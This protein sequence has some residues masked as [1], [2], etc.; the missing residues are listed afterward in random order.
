[1]LALERSFSRLPDV[2]VMQSLL[3]YYTD[4]VNYF[5][6]KEEPI[7]EY[8]Q[9]KIKDLVAKMKPAFG[10]PKAKDADEKRDLLTRNVM[11]EMQE[12]NIHS[13]ISEELGRHEKL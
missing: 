7:C 1:M 5:S 9:Q 2:G 8:F 13:Q 10:K 4:S 6:E 3:C 12:K 11:K